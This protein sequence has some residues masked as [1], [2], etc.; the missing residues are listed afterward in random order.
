M[1]RFPLRVSLFSLAIAL[2]VSPALAQ[3]QADAESGSD[4]TIIVTAQKR[5]QSIQD[6]PLTV[7]AIN[8]EQMDKIGI[9]EFDELSAYIPGLNI[10]EQSANNPGF[11][12]RG[13][14]SDSGSAQ[15]APRVTIYLNGIDVSRSRGSYF[16]LFD[17]DRVEVVKGPQATLFGTAATIGAISVITAKPEPGFSADLRGSYGNFNLYE[18][19]AMINVGNDKIAGRIAASYKKRDGYVRNIAGEPGTTSARTTGNTQADLN[20]IDQFAIR[21]SLRIWPTAESTMDF[22]FNYE[23]Q[24]NPGTAFKS[25]SIAPTGGTTSPYTFAELGGAPADL[26]RAILGLPKLGL[27]RE[28]YDASVTFQTP[29]GD[30]WSLTSITGYRKFDSL[31]TFDADGTAL[32]FLEFAED[33]QGEQMSH[34]TR[35]AYDSDRLRG[36]FGFN[37]FHEEGTQAVP[38]LTDE[39]TY[40]S[41]A[42]FPA[43]APVRN[44]VAAVLGVPGASTCAALNSPNPARNATAILTRGA[45]TVLPYSSTFTNGGKNTVYSGFAD[46]TFDISDRFELSAGVRYLYEE[47]ASTYTA[48]QP[49]SQ[50][51]ASLGVRGVSLLGAVDTAGQVFRVR[52][53]FDAWL[54]R[55]NALYRVTDDVNVYATISK[56]RRSPVLNL[57]ASATAAGPVPN[58]TLVA[59]EKIWNYEG[60][61]KATFGGFSGSIGAFYQD[62]SN[63]QTSFFNQQ[64]QTVPV[65]AGNAGNFGVEVEGALRIGNN[66]RL[67]ANYAYIDAKIESPNPA[68]QDNRFRLQ[69]KHKAAAGIDVTLPVGDSAEL[70]FFPT[71]TYSSKQFFEIPNSERLSE[72]GYVLINARAGVRFDEGRYEITAFARNLANEDY[73]IDAGNTGGAFGTA[74]FIAGEPRLYGVQVAAKF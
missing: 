56:G 67:F 17:I 24:R 48:V 33:A 2:S 70:F 12:I 23:Q 11:V 68:F 19:R 6:V 35:F 20:G 46:L 64:G 13:I 40:I 53:N 58:F 4:N 43:F 1:P 74:T 50:I 54:P 60:G 42:P 69:S 71:V 37:V 21:G 59:E 36:F 8:G 25:G 22:V 28:V 27:N 29:M 65:N 31:E 39:G 52:D 62:Y 41:C 34:E 38:F 66:V 61:V 47:R 55:F 14:T 16:D 57:S 15:I 73:L 72:D 5:E 10:Q 44:N 32:F 7:S 51:F 3:D 49:G 26:S 63:F 45:A 30:G 18:G 9:D